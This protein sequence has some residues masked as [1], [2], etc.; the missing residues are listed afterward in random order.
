MNFTYIPNWLSKG[1]TC[2]HCNTKLS[3]KYEVAGKNVLQQM[4]LHSWGSFGSRS[5]MLNSSRIGRG[6]SGSF[7]RTTGTLQERFLF[8][9][10]GGTLV[11]VFTAIVYRALR[12]LSR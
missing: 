11:V 9:V 7:R 8:G 5:E 3:V 6:I 1:F 12:G 4:C 10:L 2:S